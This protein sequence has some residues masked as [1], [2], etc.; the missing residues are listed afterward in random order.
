MGV[1]LLNLVHTG[2]LKFLAIF[3]KLA[4]NKHGFL[5]KISEKSRDTPKSGF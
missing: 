1:I 2:Y 5:S 3:H 4:A